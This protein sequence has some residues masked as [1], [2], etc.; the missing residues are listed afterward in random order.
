MGQVVLDDP[1]LD[2][3]HP[4]TRVFLLA[5]YWRNRYFNLKGTLTMRKHE[6][7]TWPVYFREIASGRLSFSVRE[8][9]G[10]G[11]QKGD[12]VLLCEWDPNIYV[13]PEL[14]AKLEAGEVED[15]FDPRYTGSTMELEITYVE[16]SWGVTPNHVIIGFGSVPRDVKEPE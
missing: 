15:S 4:F 2:A 12:V 1:V 14:K 5:E 3:K 16:S 13:N 10:R 7:K 6:L 11:F 9:L 8:N